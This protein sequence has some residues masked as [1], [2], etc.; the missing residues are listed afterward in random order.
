MPSLSQGRI[1]MP[2]GLALISIHNLM[3]HDAFQGPNPPNPNQ[4]QPTNQPTMVNDGS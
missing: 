2:S 3:S 1:R 4:S